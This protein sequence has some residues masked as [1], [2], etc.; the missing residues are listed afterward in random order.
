MKM[1]PPSK[2]KSQQIRIN[3]VSKE[4]SLTRSSRRS[5]VSNTHE[6]SG[7]R[8]SKSLNDSSVTI[9]NRLVR[10][11][12]EN[13]VR[14]LIDQRNAIVDRPDYALN[15]KAMREKREINAPPDLVAVYKKLDAIELHI[16]GHKQEAQRLART[17]EIL[18]GTNQDFDNY[19]RLFE[20][21]DASR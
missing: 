5:M 21:Y 9:N 8:L 6:L 12:M 16:E 19:R 3:D 17:R 13:Q 7:S 14:T 1:S 20:E 4:L 2:K 18:T 10:Q 15:L 11:I